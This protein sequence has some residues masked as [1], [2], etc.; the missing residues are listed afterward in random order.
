MILAAAG[1]S[2][3]VTTRS[4]YRADRRDSDLIVRQTGSQ[5]FQWYVRGGFNGNPEDAAGM[6][7]STARYVL[8]LVSTSP[9]HHSVIGNP[10]HIGIVSGCEFMMLQIPAIELYFFRTSYTSNSS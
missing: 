8:Q 6:H 10:F 5:L 1:G 7:G 9:D 3:D 4:T 2:N